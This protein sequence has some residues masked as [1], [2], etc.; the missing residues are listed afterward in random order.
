MRWTGGAGGEFRPEGVSRLR[1]R[2]AENT[3]LRSKEEVLR[4]G[5]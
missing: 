4:R 2:R 5:V 1:G 3:T